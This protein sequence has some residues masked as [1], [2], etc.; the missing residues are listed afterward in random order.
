MIERKH[1][2][3]V[4]PSPVCLWLYPWEYPWDQDLF[5]DYCTFL[6]AE[7]RCVVFC[8]WR[9]RHS[10]S[11][12]PPA[13]VSCGTL[14]LL[15]PR[16]SPLPFVLAFHSSFLT[17]PFLQGC[18][19]GLDVVLSSLLDSAP[20]CLAEASSSCLCRGSA[21]PSLFGVILWVNLLFELLS[22]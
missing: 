1:E 10:G 6:S 13:L 20:S 11:C 14:Q 19:S 22:F 7:E 12:T 15:F 3:G 5:W 17:V 18:C 9:R 4:N 21:S 8:G 2:T 16:A